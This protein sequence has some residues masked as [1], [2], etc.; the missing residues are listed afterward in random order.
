M[1]LTKISRRMSVR[2]LTNYLNDYND[3]TTPSYNQWKDTY[4]EQDKA[5]RNLFKSYLLRELLKT[6][7]FSLVKGER[8]SYSDPKDK[9]HESKTK[10][11][12]RTTESDRK[13][14]CRSVYNKNDVEGNLI[15][16]LDSNVSEQNW[17]CKM[18]ARTD[19]KDE[20]DEKDQKEPQSQTLEE[21]YNASRRKNEVIRRMME[22]IQRTDR[23]FLQRAKNWLIQN[24]MPNNRNI[25]WNEQKVNS[26]NITNRINNQMGLRM[27]KEM[28]YDRVVKEGESYV[29]IQ[30]IGNGIASKTKTKNKW[31]EA[32]KIKNKNGVFCIPKKNTKEYLEVRKIMSNL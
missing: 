11:R 31:I 12:A 5:D 18:R 26:A 16:Y 27:L 25:N 13:R 7:D 10:G 23:E 4:S 21:V 22:R 1:E 19:Q 6:G 15:R 24:D 28:G 2:E 32:I 29:P 30:L 17:T 3:G 9:H 8:I 20:K 14:V